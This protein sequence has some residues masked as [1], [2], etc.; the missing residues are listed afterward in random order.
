MAEEEKTI[1]VP[2]RLIITITANI[3]IQKMPPEVLKKLGSVEELKEWAASF[4]LDMEG[5]PEFG[6]YCSV[7][8]ATE[9]VL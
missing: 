4:K 9:E 3:D 7:N 1:G 6:K 2:A 8:I 5:D